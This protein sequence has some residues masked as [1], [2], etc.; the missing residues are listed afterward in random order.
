M[1]LEKNRVT[2]AS[3]FVVSR[4]MCVRHVLEAVVGIRPA[5]VNRGTPLMDV[6]LPSRS[7]HHMSSRL[8]NR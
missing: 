3:V 8:T 1:F 4:L 2:V 5:L 6:R 7:Q